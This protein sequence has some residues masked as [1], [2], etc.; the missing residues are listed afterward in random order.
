MSAAV[1]A[2]AAAAAARVSSNR[3]SHYRS[4]QQAV[5]H[6]RWTPFFPPS[7]QPA[8]LVPAFSRYESQKQRDWNAFVQYLKIHHPHLHLPQCSG[9]HVLEFLE[10]RY[11]D[12]KIHTQNCT[13]SVN[14]P[15]PPPPCSCPLNEAWSSLDGLVGRLLVAFEENV[16]QPEMNPFS[17]RIVKLYLRK[18][19]ESE[20]NARG[21]RL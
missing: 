2:A 18:A 8:L 20:A 10:G 17:A 7:P 9:V 19:K 16:G 11:G 4:N 21:H 15:E 6:Q 5:N 1:A 12:T 14:R 3:R 13:F